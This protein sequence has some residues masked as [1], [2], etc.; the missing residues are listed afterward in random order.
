ML[1]QSTIGH[2]SHGSKSRARAIR[3]YYRLR[4]A[5]IA[6]RALAENPR[7]SIDMVYRLMDE[8]REFSRRATEIHSL[9]NL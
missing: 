6:A 7:C 9:Y 4:R 8:S 5:S 2:M 1:S 3:E